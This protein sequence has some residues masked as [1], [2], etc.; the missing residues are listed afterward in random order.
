M[1]EQRST[2]LLLLLIPSAF[3]QPLPP[4]WKVIKDSRGVCQIRVPPEWIPLMESAG[5]AVLRDSTTAIAVVTSQ[6]QQ[7]FKVLP[8]SLQRI[9]GIHK[10][11][12]FENSLKRVF[13]QDKTSVQPEDPNGYSLS[14]PGR[15]GTCSC[16]LTAL[17]SV[18]E[19]TVRK[20]ALSLAPTPE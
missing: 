20:I 6:P 12:M 13:Y 10:E 8:D 11:K 18:P 17:P 1:R 2:L 5:A 16:R 14:V 7:E 4:A 3:A 9:L 19:E 15:S